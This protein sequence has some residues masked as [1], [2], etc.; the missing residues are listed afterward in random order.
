MSVT[1]VSG[2]ILLLSAC[3]NKE[4]SIRELEILSADMSLHS[5][6][7]SEDEW[8]EALEKFQELSDD[9][10]GEDLT[11]EQ[12]QRLGKVKGEITGYIVNQATRE[13]GAALRDVLNEA[14]GFVDG[15]VNTAIPDAE[16]IQK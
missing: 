1:I 9:L 16:N 5:S 14:A 6:S 3:S 10:Q 8:T 12:L 4:E 11:P 15:F 2:M 13:F 7:Y